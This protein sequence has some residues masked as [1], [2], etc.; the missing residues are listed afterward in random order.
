MKPQPQ[1]ASMLKNQ[2]FDGFLLVRAAAQRTSSNG[3]KYLDMTLCDISGEVNAKMWD[4]LT[5]APA[6]ATV[7]RLRGVM[8]EYNGRPTWPPSPP[9]RRSPRA[10]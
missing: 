5:P 9:A 3:S 1:L 7:L 2:A 10:R 4:G 8:L 6:P